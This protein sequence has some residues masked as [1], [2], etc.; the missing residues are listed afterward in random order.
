MNQYNRN[1]NK[2]GY[3][4]EEGN[5]YHNFSFKGTST[6]VTASKATGFFV[7]GLRQGVWK[8]FFSLGD[9]SYDTY[10]I[11]GRTNGLFTFYKRRNEGIRHQIIYIT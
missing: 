10:L 2:E 11:N 6:T 8:Y 3:W 1:K 9:Q 7:N 5:F 4:E